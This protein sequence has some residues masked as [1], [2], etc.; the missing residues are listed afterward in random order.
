[1]R[2]VCPSL[3]PDKAASF[4]MGLVPGRCYAYEVWGELDRFGTKRQV[5]MGLVPDDKF[6]W[7]WCRTT[8]SDGVGAGL[9]DYVF[10]DGVGA[11]IELMKLRHTKL[12]KHRGEEAE[13]ERGG[14]PEIQ[15][16]FGLGPDGLLRHSC[17][18][19]RTAFFETIGPNAASMR[20]CMPSCVC[21]YAF[22]FLRGDGRS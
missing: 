5:P 22:L 4:P 3:V 13:R 2:R 7:G 8:S 1:M 21:S 17:T 14:R 20:K 18:T 19:W 9:Q 15:V 16:R 11:G 12:G 10:P 6:R